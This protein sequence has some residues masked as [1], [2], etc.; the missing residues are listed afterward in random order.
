ML[1]PVPVFYITVGP[2]SQNKSSFTETVTFSQIKQHILY[3]IIQ[4]TSSF[5]NFLLKSL[6][7]GALSVYFH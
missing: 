7:A 5:S 6:T 3:Y 4:K 2:L 1:Y